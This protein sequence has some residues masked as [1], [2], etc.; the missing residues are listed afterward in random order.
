MNRLARASSVVVLL[1]LSVSR[2][3]W[4][5]DQFG[6]AV[7][8]DGQEVLVLKPAVGRGPAAIFVYG[9]DE[10]GAWQI[11]ERLHAPGGTQTGEGF[12]GSMWVADGSLLVAGGD[13]DA[14]VGAR[15]WRRDAVGDWVESEEIALSSGADGREAN[16]ALDLGT[17]MRIL[18][19][20]ARV[21]AMDGDIALVALPGGSGAERGTHVFRRGPDSDRWR[22]PE[23]L[24]PAE[25][26]ASAQFG[27]AL[28]IEGER[29]LVG[30]PRSG[31]SGA[32]YVFERDRESGGW[33]RTALLTAEDLGTGAALGSTVAL[34]G[35]DAIVGAPGSQASAG[36]V[37]T[38]SIDSA[39]GAWSERGRLR[40]PES[41]GG[42]AFGSALSVAGD[43][44]L[45]GAPGRDEGRGAVYSF[46]RGATNPTWGNP[47]PIRIAGLEPGDRLGS[48]VAASASVAVAGAPL[49]EGGVGRAAAFTRDD[50]GRWKHA[51]WLDPGGR[52]ETVTGAEMRC[53]AG[54]AGGFACHDVDLL[55]FLPISAL[56]GAPGE[57]VSDLWGWTDPETGREYGLVGRSGGAVFVDITDPTEP[58]Y[59][60]VLPAPRSGARDLKVYRDHLFFTGDGAGAHGL[61]VF[62]LTRLRE[63][64]EAP[65]TFEPDAR[66]DGIHSAHNLVIDTESGFAYT[67]GNSG[68]GE[69]CGGG[70]HMVDIRDPIDPTFAGCYVDRETGLIWQGRTHDA[71]CVVY[72]GPDQDHRNR[73]ICFAS[74]ETALRIVD[75]TDK[76]EP[77]P[78]SAASYP[79][80]AY[81]HQG[82][83]TEDQRYFYLDDE[84]DELVGRAERTRMLI[85]DV[86]DLDDPVL[87]GEHFGS[88]GATDHNL[89]VKGDRVYQAN[90][91]AG[92]RVLDIS[93]PESPVEVAYFDT[94]PWEGDPAGFNGAWTAF[95]F[96]ESGTVI[97]SSMN[98]GLFVLKPRRQE[99]VP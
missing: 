89:Y 22:D 94:T 82:W 74:N 52:L 51:A 81:V 60:G 30:A 73:E 79:G 69:T 84:L 37:L 9:R 35:G 42:D 86:S 98:E 7:A 28:A 80:L 39:T 88:T 20:S 92:L 75:V 71:Q 19:P 48:S 6:R 65:V 83:L 18:Q 36:V 4:S 27:A 23:T 41:A 63:V 78:L 99:L 29:I 72:R 46:E 11:V 5:Q 70:L 24:T 44:L 96:F 66:Y 91:Q 13:P 25:V 50:A 43:Q 38:Y 53:D 61:L 40:S 55:A 56:G 90:Y 76:T 67:V 54:E 14:R 59:L 32:A 31:S 17:V 93:D 1:L 77:R 16:A 85:W 58:V 45:V 8:V 2:T 26:P 95:P 10:D 62:D 34:D 47:R 15:S 87:V 33:T 64:R 49:A 12:S 57:R 3:G 97:V 68:G 21:V